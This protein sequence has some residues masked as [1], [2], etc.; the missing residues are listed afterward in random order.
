MT[1]PLHITVGLDQEPASALAVDWAIREA[2]RQPCR[3]TLLLAFDLLMVEPFDAD[4]LLDRQRARVLEAVP[5]AV[6]DTAL[7]EG[8]IP[9]V[10]T[11]YSTGSD[12]LVI[13]SH[14][15]R[16]WQ[17]VLS[18]NLPLTMARGSSCPIVIVPDDWRARSGSVVVGLDDDGS[19]DAALLRAAEFA[20]TGNGRLRVVH[21]WMR[22][23]LAIDPVGLYLASE[24]SDSEVRRAHRRRLDAAAR[25]VSRRVPDLVVE[26]VLHEGDAVPGLVEVSGDA[27][28]VVI[29]SHRRGPIAG[30]LLGSVARGLLHHSPVPVCVVPPKREVASSARH[31]LR[32]GTRV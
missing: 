13:G 24:S 18:G 17:S 22:P 7:A 15:T 32:S 31:V 4:S 16:H 8:S 23:E 26:E 3:I 25:R 20:R 10:L 11:R 9:Q 19:S 1:R 21:A 5:E 30:M 14:R 27:E 12:L 6:V 29:G 2:S 28:L